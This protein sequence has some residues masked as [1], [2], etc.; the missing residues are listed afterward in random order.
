MK[1]LLLLL[2]LL[3]TACAGG[4]GVTEGA[5]D[6]AEA[7]ADLQTYDGTVAYLNLEGGFYGIVTARGDDLLPTNLPAEYEEDGL[8]VRVT[9]RFLEDVATFVMWGR[10]FEVTEITRR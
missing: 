7:A 1:R 6:D 8:A 3:V 2:A 10:P 9:G 4:D 5:P